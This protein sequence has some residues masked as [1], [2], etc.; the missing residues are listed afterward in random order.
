MTLPTTT[1]EGRK[2]L[3]LHDASS[4]S[5]SRSRHYSK[6][7]RTWFFKDHHMVPEEYVWEVDLTYI[8]CGI[9]GWGYLFSVFDVF[10]R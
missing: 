10:T 6:K 3:E 8:H 9:D 4:R 2:G 5:R 7:L 1:V